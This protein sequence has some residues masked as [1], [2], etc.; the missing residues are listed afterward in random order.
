MKRYLNIVI[1]LKIVKPSNNPVKTLQ[2][3]NKHKLSCEWMEYSPDWNL[4]AVGCHDNNIYIKNYCSN[5]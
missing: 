3:L 1:N 5:K 2:T 4:L